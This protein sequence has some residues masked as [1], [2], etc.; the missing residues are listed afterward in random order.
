MEKKALKYTNF[1]MIIFIILIA[2]GCLLTLA[3]F[4][5]LNVQTYVDGIN[6]YV[7][8]L[9]V[10][11]VGYILSVSLYFVG[12]LIFGILAG[13]RLVSFNFWFLNFIRN[14]NQKIIVKPGKIYGIGC[15]VNMS[16]NKENPNYKLYLFGGTLFSIPFFIISMIIAILLNQENDLKYYLIFIFS[17][18][19]FIVVGNLIPLRYDSFNDGFTL[20]L[21]HL[22]KSPELFHRNMKQFEAL[23]NN[24]STLKYYEYK[25]PYSPFELEGLY[26]NYYYL[27]DNKEY[28]RALRMCDTLVENVDKI[29]DKSKIY[30][31]YVGKIYEYCRQKRFEE[32]DRYYWELNH[33]IRN[34]VRNKRNF[35][36]IKICLYVAAYMESNY[37]EYLD[38]YYRKNKL[39]KK[40]EY[41]SR[42]DKEVDIINETIKSIQED[43][44]DWYVE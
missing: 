17:F 42:I 41:L 34:V 27:I 43:H 30:L 37:D 2:L 22:D 21:I 12:K 4:Q 1:S 16:L 15:R 9:L 32:S 18:I 29:I 40:Y 14:S 10:L 11:I 3:I 5:L 13:Y 20:R 39:S 36:S 38:L 25:A 24:R 8:N 31:G 28:T 33:D 44:Q 6:I 35:E 26:Y 7:F 19:P 23:V